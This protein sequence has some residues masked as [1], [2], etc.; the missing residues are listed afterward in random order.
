MI[1]LVS[2]LKNNLD[3]SPRKQK[4]KAKAPRKKTVSRLNHGQSPKHF[5]RKQKL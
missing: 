2:R 5:R 3:I 1:K 4:I